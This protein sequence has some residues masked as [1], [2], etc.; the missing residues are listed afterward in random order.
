MFT[1]RHTPVRQSVL[2]HTHQHA[3]AHY[4]TTLD[5]THTHTHTHV[6]LILVELVLGRNSVLL[7]TVDWLTLLL[8]GLLSHHLSS[9]A[10]HPVCRK[11]DLRLTCPIVNNVS[12][13]SG[14]A[15]A[16]SESYDLLP[17]FVVCAVRGIEGYILLTRKK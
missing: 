10:V 14:D 5:N 9:S 1:L 11:L 7:I 3:T 2:T 6:T 17:K 12:N 16:Y 8:I 15:K 4:S 13:S